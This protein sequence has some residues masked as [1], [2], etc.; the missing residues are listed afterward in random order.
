MNARTAQNKGRQ[1]KNWKG[2][3]KNLATWKKTATEELLIMVKSTREALRSD[4]DRRA[5]DQNK[6]VNIYKE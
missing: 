2:K 4:A 3:I 1:K 5:V 6:F